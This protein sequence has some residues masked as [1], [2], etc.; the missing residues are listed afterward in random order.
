MESI[1]FC[2]IILLNIDSFVLSDIIGNA[3][4]NTLRNLCKMS[5]CNVV[6][7]NLQIFL[8][9]L[10]FTNDLKLPDL[11]GYLQSDLNKN[12]LKHVIL[13]PIHHLQID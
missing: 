11:I 12:Y 13:I 2:G 4:L 7:I 9:I 8:I 3:S 6:P 5:E 10:E 1:T